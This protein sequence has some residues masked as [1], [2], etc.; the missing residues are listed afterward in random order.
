MGL[1]DR[2]GRPGS[3]P[4]GWLPIGRWG[5]GGLLGI[6]RGGS[7][8]VVHGAWYVRVCVSASRLNGKPFQLGY[9]F[10]RSQRV[11]LNTRRGVTAVYR[12]RSDSGSIRQLDS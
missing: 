4:A 12:V 5:R 6:W 9:V 3:W 10:D 1:I 11:N 8:E 7:I 2:G